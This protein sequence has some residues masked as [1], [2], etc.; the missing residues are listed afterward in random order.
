MYKHFIKQMYQTTNVFRSVYNTDTIS[1]HAHIHTQS[2][3]ILPYTMRKPGRGI[4]T[5][6]QLDL[7]YSDRCN[8]QRTWNA[9][10]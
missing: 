8:L 6:T 5:L 1:I 2:Y 7:K 3:N 9:G 10:N 4:V